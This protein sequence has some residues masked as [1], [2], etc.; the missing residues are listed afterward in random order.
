M[1]SKFLIQNERMK[2]HLST[3]TTTTRKSELALIEQDI[4]IKIDLIVSGGTKDG[5]LRVTCESGKSVY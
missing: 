2:L 3:A 4:K 1:P 5:Y